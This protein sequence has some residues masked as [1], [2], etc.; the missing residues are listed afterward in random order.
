MHRPGLPVLRVTGRGW[1]VDPS[2]RQRRL[3]PMPRSQPFSDVLTLTGLTLDLPG[4]PPG[5]ADP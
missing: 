2:G 4:A 5:Q 1:T 3:V